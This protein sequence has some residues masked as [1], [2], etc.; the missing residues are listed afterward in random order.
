MC[1][2]IKVRLNVDYLWGLF[3]R[4]AKSSMSIKKS[5]KFGRLRSIFGNFLILMGI[6]AGILMPALLS[7]D[8]AL[9]VPTN[10]T[11]SESENTDVELPENDDTA[12]VEDTETQAVEES[13]ANSS[14]GS[15]GATCSESMKKVGWLVC[16]IAGAVSEAVDWI[17]E[18]IEDLLVIEPIKAEDGSPVYEIWKYCLSFT[19]IVFIIFLLVVIYSQITGVG[20]N[21]YGIKKALPKLIVAAIMVNLSFLICVLAVDVSNIIGKSLRGIFIAVQEATIA[22]SGNS[23]LGMHVPV[24]QVFSAIAGGGAIAIGAMLIGFETGAIWM[25]IPVVLGAIVSVATGLITIAMRQA[26]VTILIMIAPLAFVAYILPN[27]E[28]LYRKWKSLFIRMLTFYPLF[29]LL[30]GASQLAG[31]ALM[32]SA[33][34]G[35]WMILGIAVQIFPLFFSVSLMKM[36]GTFLGDINAKLRGIT[37]GM[38]ARNRAWADSHRTLSK[39]RHLAEGRPT[40][41]SLRLMQFLNTRKIERDAETAEQADLAKMRALSKR[42]RSFYDKNGVPNRRGEEEYA[43]QARRMQYQFDI[44]RHNHNMNKGMGQLDAVRGASEAKRARLEKLDIM[45]VKAAD[46]L[47]IESAR[48]EII[49]YENAK[50]FHSRMEAAINAHFDDLNEGNREYKRHEMSE[51]E[52]AVARA[53]YSSAHNIMEGNLRDVQYAAA[54][55][56]HGYDSQKKIVETKM[57]KYFDLTPPT[58]DVEYRLGELTRQKNAQ[59]D[60]DMILSGLRVLNQRGDTDIVRRQMENVLNSEN[61][62]KLGSHASQALASFL[63]FEVKDSDPFLRRFGKYINLETAQVYN[64]AT[65]RQNKQLTLNEYITGEYED[66]E[67]E[68]TPGAP[69]VART[70]KSKRPM[71]TLLEGTSLD[72][73]ERTAFSNL[74]EMLVN[75]YKTDGRL[76]VEKYLAK[77][78]EVETAIGPAFISASLKYLS[79]SEQLK[80]AVAFL[81]GYDGDTARWE[82]NGDDLYG[83]ESAEKYFRKKTIDYLKNQTPTQILGLRSDYYTALKNHLSDEYENADMSDWSA[84]AIREHEDIIKERAEIQTRY[85]DLPADEAKKRRDADMKTLRDKMAGAQFRQILDSKGKLNQIY[86]TRRSGA[87]NNAKDWVRAWL[88]LDNEV[89]ITQK[90]EDDRE[91]MKKKLA[92][93]RRKAGSDDSTDGPSTP[94]VYT[95]EDRANYVGKI[96]DI[97]NDLRDDDET[98]FKESLQYVENELGKNSYIATMYRRFRKNDKYAD[99]YTL[100]EYLNDL[101]RDPENY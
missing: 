51:S 48:G 35:F 30:F 95:A 17:Y 26:V 72:G 85:G 58:K 40:T 94:S 50:G 82:K 93:E 19:N 31:Y 28:G 80:N 10:A 21:N 84:E 76:D 45:N 12:D 88:D 49:D 100:R 96:E 55:A 20:I 3:N 46:A 9:A 97:W 64:N 43:E 37:S 6:L 101:L 23:S 67:P 62:I 90:L 36:S 54:T 44:D 74:D 59:A 61:G 13:S 8:M 4:E 25:L 34:D 5:S 71:S 52:R 53:R 79:G 38:V 63:M 7:Q 89:V 33:K 92:E 2:I 77:R 98:F 24:A 60:I 41:P 69:R 78:N 99:S 32:V 83:S 14:V 68:T 73:V 91:A 86:R 27:T 66:W 1:A 70:G 16:P 47:K 57:Q 42:A 15:S 18:K 87:A 75:A 56:A 11:T 81:T 39:Q 29:S 22:S 65:K